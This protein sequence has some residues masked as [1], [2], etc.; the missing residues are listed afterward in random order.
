MAPLKPWQLVEA[1]INGTQF[2][3]VYRKCDAPT[4]LEVPDPDKVVAVMKLGAHGDALWAS[5]VL[6]HLKD[7]GYYVIVYT[8]DTGEEVLRHDPHIDRLIKFE[9]RV[10]MG[11]LGELFAWIEQKY[12]N[13]RILVECVEGTLLPSPQKI[14]YHFPKPLRE[15][16]MNHNY[17]DLHHMQARVPLEPRQKF[18]P[19]EE[20][21][22]F[23]NKV[24]AGLQ[25]YV[26]V[27]VPTGSSITKKWPYIVDL[28][29]RL[30]EREDVSVVVLGDRRG[31]QVRGSPATPRHRHELE[32]APGHDLLPTGERR[33]RAGDRIAELRGVRKGREEG[34]A[35]HPLDAREPDARL[36]EYGGPSR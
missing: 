3:H 28:A 23:A 27:L 35:A 24:R 30:L 16:L 2:F 26:V 4:V 14:Q 10:P 32:R 7:Q 22:A 33:G 6:P 13:A 36:A 8:Q 17:L 5:S 29:K 20:E 18:Y 21:K 25:P 31:L 12:K 11:E 19:N 1:R 9:S 34:G 15:K